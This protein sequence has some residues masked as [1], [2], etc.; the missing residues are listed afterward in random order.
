M[1]FSRPVSVTRMPTVVRHPGTRCVS[2]MR[3]TTVSGVAGM[4]FVE[5]VKTAAI[6]R[7]IVRN[8][9][10]ETERATPTERDAPPARRTADCA[11]ETAA[12][13]TEP[14]VVNIRT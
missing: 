1:S 11:K 4:E 13:V 9:A 10:V 6:A 8:R 12:S 7:R 14:R 5:R 2:T 3:V